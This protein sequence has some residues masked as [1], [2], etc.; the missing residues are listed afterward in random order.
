ML[1]QEII[2]FCQNWNAKIE[3]NKGDNLS[4]V[5]E[6]YRDL[7][8]VYNKLYNQVPDA[9]VAIGNPYVG[10]I[11]D[12]A[13]A[14]DIAIQYLGGANILANFHANN[15]DNDIDGIARLIDQE[16]F[17]IKIRNGQR[18]RNADLEILQNLRSANADIKAKAI[19]QVIYLVRCNLV[20][21]SKD[22]QEYQRLL[23]EPL[24][25]LLRTLITQLYS[26]L[27]K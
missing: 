6:R 7:F 26:E 16:V 23:L 19:L 3:A 14:T 27:S 24:T 9:L 22:Y 18:D 5:Y 4:D 1:D 11:T 2:D 13:G 25:N 10:R 12:S 17:Y 21:G 8:T 15:L 20:H